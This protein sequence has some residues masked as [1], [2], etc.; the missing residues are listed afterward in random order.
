M[1]ELRARETGLNHQIEAL[2]AQLADREVYLKL[3][4]NLEDFLTGLRDKASDAS[5]TERQRVLRLLVK[6][7][8]VGSDKITIRH[9]IPVRTSTGSRNEETPEADSEGEIRRDCP[10]RWRRHLTVAGQHLPARL[11]HRGPAS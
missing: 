6:D 4:D 9:S 10:L 3:A 11:R 8:L 2:D 5:I 1:P 7:V